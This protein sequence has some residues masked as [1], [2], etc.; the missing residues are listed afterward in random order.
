MHA[1]GVP[2]ESDSDSFDACGDPNELPIALPRGTLGVREI[3]ELPALRFFFDY[4]QFDPEV[5]T[6]QARDGKRAALARLYGYCAKELSDGYA[7]PDPM[8]RFIADRLGEIARLL[9]DGAATDSLWRNALARA[10]IGG[11]IKPQSS[12][13]FNRD[14]AVSMFTRLRAEGRKS[15]DADAEIAAALSISAAS[16]KRLRANSPTKRVRRS[17]SR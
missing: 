15:A 10:V 1:E 3:R 6:A 17:Q 12:R 2:V 11:T 14:I 8:Q 16:A 9:G 7:L 4:V 13:R 5:M